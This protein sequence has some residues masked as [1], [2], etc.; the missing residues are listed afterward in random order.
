MKVTNYYK[1]VKRARD[2]LRR[3]EDAQQKSMEMLHEQ[4]ALFREVNDACNLI[5]D[6]LCRPSTQPQDIERLYAQIE[7]TLHKLSPSGLKPSGLLRLVELYKD[8]SVLNKEVLRLM[9]E[10][11]KI[12][13]TVGLW[14]DGENCDV[15][16]VLYGSD[17]LIEELKY[18][19]ARKLL[20]KYGQVLI[21]D[22]HIG[23]ET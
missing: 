8:R 1:K 4:L 23:I 21:K 18:R 19:I 12:L 5:G 17:A 9:E 7:P 15:S 20:L 3:I 6:V 14:A 11:E 10:R 16:S 2:R 13:C 22:G